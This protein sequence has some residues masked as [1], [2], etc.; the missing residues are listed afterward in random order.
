MIII[1][2]IIIIIITIIK[3]TEV[4]LNSSRVEIRGISGRSRFQSA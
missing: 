1:I 3:L 4:V 2:I